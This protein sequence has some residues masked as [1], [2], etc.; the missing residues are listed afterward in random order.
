MDN[1]VKTPVEIIRILPDSEFVKAYKFIKL[2]NLLNCKS[3]T[4]YAH[5]N[6]YWRCVFSKKKPSR[7][8]YTVECTEEWWRIKAMLSHIEQYKDELNE[9]SENLIDLIK[10]AYDC[11]KCNDHC[12]GPNPF[13]IDGT[14]YKKCL[15]CSFYFSKLNEIDQDSLINLLKREVQH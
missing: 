8:L 10:T 15:G 4:R 14:E 7:V 1:Q 2:G 5:S 13:I 12:K 6:K 3:Q 11:H 9:C